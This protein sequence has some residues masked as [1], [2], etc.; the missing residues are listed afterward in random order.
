MIPADGFSACT[1]VA[2]LASCGVRAMRTLGVDGRRTYPEC[3]QGLHPTAATA[4]SFDSQF[5]I[6]ARLTGS[7]RLHLVPLD[8]PMS[9]RGRILAAPEERLPALVLAETLL[10][11]A[12][13]TLD[14]TLTLIRT[15]AWSPGRPTAKGGGACEVAANCLI[16]ADLRDI[17]TRAL[18]SGAR[19]CGPDT[20]IA[21]LPAPWQPRRA[22]A[23]VQSLVSCR[24]ADGPQHWRHTDAPQGT[25]WF[26]ALLAALTAGAISRSEVTK[27]VEEGLA[28]PSLLTQ[29]DRHLADA[30]LLPRRT[31]EAERCPG[32]AATRP[33]QDLGARPGPNPRRHP[34]P[35]PRRTRP[36]RPGAALGLPRVVNPG[37]GPPDPERHWPLTQTP[38]ATDR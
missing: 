34:G 30:L 29:I 18:P 8:H 3:F 4:P 20:Q 15:D 6:L 23:A 25:R 7:Y 26:A 9:A 1:G 32:A 37:R 28:R 17:W 19:L 16:E 12:S 24:P 31:W 21:A 11:H 27:A 2:L 10:Q 35:R 5:A 33:E 13:L 22:G 14:L 38:V 36:S